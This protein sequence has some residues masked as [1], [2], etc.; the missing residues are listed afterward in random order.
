V[1]EAV[2]IAE[3]EEVVMRKH[4]DGR[5]RTVLVLILCLALVI[6]VIFAWEIYDQNCVVD[7][8]EGTITELRAD[9]NYLV[10]EV[11]KHR[12]ESLQTSLQLVPVVAT[13]YNPVPSQTS[14]T[15]TITA[16]NKKVREG[17]IALSRDLEEKYNFVFGDEVYLLGLGKFVF[18]DRM[19][20]RWKNRV[21]IL[22]FSE[23]RAREFGVQSSFMLVGR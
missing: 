3:K 6:G 15:P 1:G 18:E 19:N 17:M 5:D 7:R 14:E 8:L 11:R 23:K 9:V 16:S 12:Q 2:W 21:D 20:K 22:M 4:S 10:G 13:A